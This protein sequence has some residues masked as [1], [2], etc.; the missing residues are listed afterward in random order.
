VQPPLTIAEYERLPEDTEHRWELQEG[1]TAM[2][3][4]LRPRRALAMAELRDQLKPQLPGNL[5]ALP[6]THLDLELS[7]PDAPGHVRRP[8]LVVVDWAA[9]ERS[10]R[11]GTLLRASEVKLVVE[12]LSPDSV[13]MNN[14]IK[15]GEYADA[16]IPHYWIID[17]NEPVSLVDCHLAGEFGYQDNGG[18]SGVFTTSSPFSLRVDLDALTRPIAP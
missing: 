7:P 6:G 5:C 1:C 12:I 16:G 9:Y 8:D 11:E 18:V 13:R 17:V 3:P 10:D 4:P 2:G 15:R 14:V